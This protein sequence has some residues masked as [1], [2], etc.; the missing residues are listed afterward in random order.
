MPPTWLTFLAWASLAAGFLSAA[1]TLFDVHGRGLRQ[2]TRVMEAVWR[3]TALYLGPLGWLAYARLGR[4]RVE[5]DAG[6]GGEAVAELQGIAVSAGHCG[7]GC[8]LGDVVGDWVVFAGSITIAGAALWP[9]Y[10]LVFAIAY[11]L[12]ILVWLVRR[13]INHQI[14]RPTLQAA[15]ASAATS[16]E[17]AA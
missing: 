5:R 16:R 14:G 17:R 11:V 9:G 3:I 15:A 1:A 8:A 12:G 2:P 4:P 7:A 10:V 13:G 6:A